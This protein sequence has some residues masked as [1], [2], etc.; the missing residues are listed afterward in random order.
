MSNWWFWL[1]RFSQRLL[2]RASAYG[3]LA[4][5]AALAAAGGAAFVPDE[6]S[7]RLGGPA[8]ENILYALASS[9]LAVATFSVS[10]VVVAYTAASAQLTPRAASFITAD[11]ATQRALATFV[12]AFLFTVV[13]LVALG[14]NYYGPGGR[15]ILFLATLLM[16]SLVAITLLLWIDRLSRLA[17]HSH[18]LEQIEARTRRALYLRKERPHL[19]GKKLTRESKQ[20]DVLCSRKIGYVA[21]IDPSK[22]Q[23]VAEQLDCAVQVLVA[24]GDF[25]RSG[26]ALARLPGCDALSDEQCATLHGAFAF[27]ETRTFEQDPLYG[28]QVLV[29]VAARALSPGVND[30]GTAVLVTDTSYRLVAGWIEAHNGKPEPEVEFRRLSARD[31]DTCALIAASLAEIARSGAGEVLVAERVQAALAALASADD[32]AAAACAKEHAALAL[33]RAEAALTFEADIERVR[34]AQT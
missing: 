29:E 24:P 30:P 9:L 21:N 22:L 14:A 5:V 33:E 2:V 7:E 34:A 12:G 25:V 17:Q 10:A 3:A 6:L 19:G 18:L 15:T 27:N 8:V 11:G 13:A 31:I 28:L 4:V 1:V 26:A 23:S 32:K 16:V 20:G